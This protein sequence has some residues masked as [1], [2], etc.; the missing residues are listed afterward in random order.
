MFVVSCNWILE[1]LNKN[2]GIEKIL[3]ALDTLGFEVKEVKSFENDYLITIEV[4]ANR[5]DML[6]H[7]GVARELAS[8]FDIELEE[9]VFVF[10]QNVEKNDSFS[11]KIDTNLCECYN[12]FVIED[13]DNTIQI[14]E[15]IQ[16]RL[17]L[18]GIESINPVVDISNYITLEYGQPTHIYDKDKFLENSLKVCE[19]NNACT[20]TDLSNKNLKLQNGDIVIK[21]NNEIVCLAGIIGSKI[22]ETNKNTKNIIIESAIFNKIP[23]RLTSKR[24]KISTL[25]S[26]RFERGVDAGNSL[27]ILNLIAQKI[28]NLCGGKLVCKFIYK[29]N[30]IF[31]KNLNLRVSRTNDILGTNLKINQ[32]LECLGK[33]K[34]ECKKKDENNI[35]VK[36]PSFRLDME[37]EIDLIEEVAR[38]IGYDI[39]EPLNP[40]TSLIYRPNKLYEKFDILRNILMGFGFNESI[41][42]SFIPS[43][44]CNIIDNLNKNNCIILQNPLSNLYDLMRPNLIYSLL[45]SLSYNYSIGNYDSSFFEIG[46]TYELDK[47]AET[48]AQETDSLGFIISGNKINSGFGINKAI[49]YDFYD[50]NSYLNSIFDYFDQKNIKFNQKNVSYMNNYYD[51]IFEN[52]NLGFIGEINKSKFIKILPNLKLIKDKIF[53]CEIKINKIKENKKILKFESKFPSIIRQYNFICPKNIFSIEI[54]NYIKSKSKLINK[55]SIKDIYKDNKM[56][57]NEHSL[58][59]EIEYRLSER[60]INSE[61]IELIENDLSTSLLKKFGMKIKEKVV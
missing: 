61:E 50:L 51:L 43:E 53:Y 39:I 36:I 23:V 60:T 37:R 47:N 9:P 8:F 18:F 34:F 26:F 21:N 45:Y 28:I 33:Y 29:I 13:I 24:L 48:F 58:L 17:K 42:Y 22:A 2:L 55:V 32:I 15:Y 59:F 19:N 38:G 49:K 11:V 10:K 12:A 7:F 14:P 6:S 44:V 4:K 41:N 57:I 3:K 16:N 5:P 27:N 52:K 30:K 46:R 31:D 56:N 20:F 54:V 25:A 35:L 40:K 1:I